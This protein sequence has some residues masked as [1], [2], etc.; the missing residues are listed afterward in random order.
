M[1][2]SVPVHWRQEATYCWH[3]AWRWRGSFPAISCA[4]STRV[5]A[6]SRPLGTQCRWPVRCASSRAR[7]V[8][9]V[10]T[11]CR[12][13]R[14]ERQGGRVHTRSAR[15]GG[16]GRG[17]AHEPGPPGGQLH[18]RPARPGPARAVAPRLGWCSSDAVCCGGLVGEVWGECGGVLLWLCTVGAEV[19]AGMI[20]PAWT[21]RKVT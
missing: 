20:V 5:C 7:G 9:T 15:V 4:S 19:G 3:R 2:A 16:R 6:C 18:L 12:R 14:S 17:R 21:S 1:R 13:A 11:A 8:H 10:V